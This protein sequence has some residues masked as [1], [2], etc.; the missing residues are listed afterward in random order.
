M[1]R[2]MIV[3]VINVRICYVEFDQWISCFFVGI[4]EL[5]GFKLCSLHN[6]VNGSLCLKCT[7]MLSGMI[8]IYEFIKIK[9]SH[10]CIIKI[11]I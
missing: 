9:F 8:F 11:C 4:I 6:E 1:N 3:Y 10:H 2:I 5:F 7:H